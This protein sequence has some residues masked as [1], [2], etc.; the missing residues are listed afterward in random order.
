MFFFLTSVKLY[1]CLLVCFESRRRQLH[2]GLKI[3]A[4]SLIFTGVLVWGLSQSD[5]FFFYNYFCFFVVVVVAAVVMFVYWIVFLLVE[6][7]V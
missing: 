6:M 7:D 1:F 5:Y 2:F 3:F 4:S